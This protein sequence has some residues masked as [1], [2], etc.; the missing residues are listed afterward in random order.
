MIQKSNRILVF[1]AG[2]QLG[3]AL[4]ISLAHHQ[5]LI[6]L[7]LPEVD[8]SKQETIYSAIDKYEPDLIINA[9]A[10][11]AVD[12]AEEE[13]AL[14]QQINGDAVGCIAEIA[15]ERKIGLIHYSTDYVFDGKKGS[16][17][18]ESDNPNPLGAY[19]RTK[20]SGEHKVQEVGGGYL[21]FRTS[22]VYTVDQECFLTK[23][24]RWARQH[25][26]LRIVDDQVSNPSWAFM[27]S[28]V[29][30]D[31]I[32][33]G[34]GEWY[35][36]FKSRSGIYHLSGKGAVSRFDW[37]KKILKL[38]PNRD[39]HVYQTLEPAKSSDFPTLAERPLYSV[40]NSSKVEDTFDIRI[41]DW[42][43]SLRAAMASQIP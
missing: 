18:L 22:W 35:Q 37:A 39:Q 1:G 28:K 42:S 13:E 3:S 38:D 24:L 12:Q 33:F 25:P 2:G 43:E 17:Y 34:G 16:E 36:Y 11:T 8:F 41:P 30:A 19:G 10:Y 40:L 26:N 14:A 6:V 7:D 4:K 29:T 15:L 31:I 21:I 5:G 32:N 23:V 27:L 20:L 9:A